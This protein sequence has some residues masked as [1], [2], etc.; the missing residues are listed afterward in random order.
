M[1]DHMATCGTLPSEDFRPL[2]ISLRDMGV[3]CCMQVLQN[4]RAD[5]SVSNVRLESTSK[6]GGVR[7]PQ[8]CECFPPKCTSEGNPFYL[9]QIFNQGTYLMIYQVNQIQIRP[10]LGPRAISGYCARARRVLS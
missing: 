6:G 2:R 3:L 7:N 5:V 10:S 4:G 8:E 1:I 9:L